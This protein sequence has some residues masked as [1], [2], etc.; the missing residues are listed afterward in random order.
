MNVELTEPAPKA[1]GFLQKAIRPHW[2]AAQRFAKT[3]VN[4]VVGT[5]A[6][7]C[8]LPWSAPFAAGQEDADKAARASAAAE[9][10]ARVAN[11][12]KDDLKAALEELVTLVDAEDERRKGVDTRLSTI[13]GLTSI[14]ATLATGLIIAQAAGTLSF[15]STWSRGLFA[16]L[17]L[18]LVVQL[19]DAIWWAIRGQSRATYEAD[20][21]TDVVRDPALSEEGWLRQRIGDKANQWL[22]HQTQNNRKVTAMAVAHRATANFVCGLIVM[23]IAGLIASFQ[24]PS[25]K[26]AIKALRENAELRSL[27]QGP[28]GVPGPKGARGLQ[29]PEGPRGEPGPAGLPAVPQESFA[30]PTSAAGR[31]E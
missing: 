2:I 18:Y 6:F 7:D 17:A 10:V 14:A 15:S 13:V 19:C 22:D 21:V 24:P 29:G 20:A 23:S 30:Q 5:A 1:P 4:K 26:P 28:Q 27:L 11:S 8:V 3:Y 25:D 16:V 31:H 9:V 12:Q